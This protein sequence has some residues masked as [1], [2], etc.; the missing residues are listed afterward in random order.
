MSYIIGNLIGRLLMS[1]F[2]VV[3]FNVLYTRFTLRLALKRAHTVW[4]WL[5]V[6]LLFML[7]LIGHFV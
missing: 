5:S 7:G 3:F 2:I 4:G 1:Y 6:A